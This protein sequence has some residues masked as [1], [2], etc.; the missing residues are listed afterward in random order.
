MRGAAWPPACFRAAN[1]IAATQNGLYRP[2]QSVL[3]GADPRLKI[4]SCLLLVVLCFAASGWAQ[5]AAVGVSVAVVGRLA[6]LPAASVGRLCWML[7]WL[8]LFTLL[9]HL[10]LSS[11]RTLWGTSWLSFDGLLSGSF[12]CTQMLLAFVVSAMLAMTTSTTSLAYALG[13]F[14]QPLRRFGCQ[15]VEWQQ[16]FLHTMDFIPIIQQEMQGINASDASNR[17]LSVPP[18]RGGRWSAWVQKLSRLLLRLVD[19]G[20][21]LARHLANSGTISAEPAGLSPLLPM[22]G[23]DRVFAATTGLMLIAYWL[24]G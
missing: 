20:D 18:A 15:T 4:L 10:L 13:W 9:M 12:V 22:A 2:G 14:L 23:H 21:A 3:H 7:R 17:A 11:G 8:L 6:A 1:L 24:A 16:L 19:R 5:L